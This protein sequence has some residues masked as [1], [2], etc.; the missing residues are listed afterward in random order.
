ML[1]DALM[2]AL[3]QTPALYFVG[4]TRSKD[5]WKVLLDFAATGHLIV[6]TAHAGSLIEAVHKIFE[7]LSVETP[8]ERSEIASKLLAVIHLRNH[9]M[10]LKA[11]IKNGKPVT[12]V[13][14]VLFPALWR[15]TPR[16]IAALTSD[17]LASLLPFRPKANPGVET[18]DGGGANS[19]SGPHVNTSVNQSGDGRTG[20]EQGGEELDSSL[21]HRWLIEQLIEDEKTNRNLHTVFGDE[22][23][24]L[25]SQ[26]YRKATEWDLQGG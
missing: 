4:E 9:E 12:P 18:R 24:N 26:A 17:G 19:Q 23:Q 8:A 1:R 21:G 25:T 14:N 3:R 6:T 22:L 5:E 10:P 15:R 13:T 20:P 2:D 16:A 11:V 7:S